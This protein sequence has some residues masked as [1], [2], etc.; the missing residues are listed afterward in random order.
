MLAEITVFPTCLFALE[1]T[2]ILIDSFLNAEI[3]RSKFPMH[4]LPLPISDTVIFI[5][6][7]EA[8]RVDRQF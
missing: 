7:I 6:K 4:E 2:N 1:I 3:R 8:T 5:L